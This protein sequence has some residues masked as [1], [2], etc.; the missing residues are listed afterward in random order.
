MKISMKEMKEK[1]QVLKT[2]NPA[3]STPRRAKLCA[4]T[5]KFDGSFDGYFDGSIEGKKKG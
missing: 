1:R 2:G 3:T 5:E 4:W